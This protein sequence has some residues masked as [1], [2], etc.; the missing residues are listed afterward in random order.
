MGNSNA[1]KAEQLGMPYK[2]FL[3]SGLFN[4]NKWYPSG[5]QRFCKECRGK[6][7]GR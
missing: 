2:L 4:A 3:E 5:V 6:G 7:V 1:K